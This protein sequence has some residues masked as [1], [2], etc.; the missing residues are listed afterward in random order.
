MDLCRH[1]THG[2]AEVAPALAEVAPS[3]LAA[4]HVAQMGHTTSVEISVL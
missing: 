1:V 2:L 3:Q 4:C